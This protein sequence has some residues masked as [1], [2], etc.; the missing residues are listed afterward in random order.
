VGLTEQGPRGLASAS[1]AIHC[2]C[3]LNSLATRHHSKCL[4]LTTTSLPAGTLIIPI[5]QMEKPGTVS[6]R[7]YLEVP[8]LVRD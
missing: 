7:K 3:C 1:I 8:W 4:V 5:L 6:V 2:G